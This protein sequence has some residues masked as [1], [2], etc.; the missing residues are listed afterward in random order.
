[1]IISPRSSST[2]TLVVISLSLSVI[3]LLTGT[4]VATARWI[5]AAITTV[6][7]TAG[8]L[9]TEV[10]GT[11]GL[12]ALD[13]SNDQ[14]TTPATLTFYNSSTVSVHYTWEFSFSSGTLDPATIALTVWEPTGTSCPTTVP[15]T[16]TFAGTLAAPPS[17]PATAISGQS[18]MVVCA[19][20]RF[21]GSIAE[22]AGGSLTTTPTVTADLTTGTWTATV[23]GDSF[24]HTIASDPLSP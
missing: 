14:Y 12:D 9:T 7:V 21:L 15:D 3:L 17:L 11:V 4:G 1:M 19:A 23:S 20:T 5:I 8:E 24:T 22:V 2:R 18:G 16:G 6:P 13:I 10:T